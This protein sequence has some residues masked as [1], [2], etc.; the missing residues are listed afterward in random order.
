MYRALPLFLQLVDSNIM[1]FFVDDC[2]C[3]YW[4][5][6]L[7][8]SLMFFR[9]FCTLK[10]YVENH[11]D[12][13]TEIF[14]YDG[15]GEFIGAQFKQLLSCIG[16]YINP[17]AHTHLRKMVSLRESMSHRSNQ[18]LSHGPLLCTFNLLV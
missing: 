13:K 14:R 5:Y 10:S 11:F 7:L 1:I 2:S 15:G 9:T 4:I 18:P 6:P 3:Y 17:H 16:F 12:S 8:L